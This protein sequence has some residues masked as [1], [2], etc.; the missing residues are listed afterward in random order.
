MNRAISMN[1]IKAMGGFTVSNGNDQ[2][3]SL[4]LPVALAPLSSM[5]AT[6]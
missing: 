4:I 3:G 1:T 6:S 5:L 2:T